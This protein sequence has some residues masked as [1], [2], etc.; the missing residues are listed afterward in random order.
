MR[1]VAI[2][3]AIRYNYCFLLHIL[4][5]QKM[6]H[7][8]SNLYS[9]EVREREVSII[10]DHDLRHMRR[11]D[12]PAML[13]HHVAPLAGHRQSYAPAVLRLTGCRG[14]SIKVLAVIT[15]CG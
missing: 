7:Q 8:I 6:T 14:Q 12:I 4:F 5:L 10:F 15:L 1:V 2:S 9:I 11:S 3:N 13:I